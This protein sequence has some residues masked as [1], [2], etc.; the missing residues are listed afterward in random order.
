MRLLA[1]ILLKIMGWRVTHPMPEGIDKAVIIMA[2]HT[3]NWD[4]V[5]GRLGFASQSIKVKIII[6][7]ESFFFPLGILLRWLGAIPVDRG[8][9]A[10][11]IKNVTQIMGNADKFYLLITPEGTRKL[12]KN[13]KKG[14]YFI[15]QQAKVPIIM[16][17]LNYKTK[18]GG[19]GPVLYP[20]GDYE[21]DMKIIED[22]YSD[23]QAM[24]P[25]KF[26]LSP[27][28][29]KLRNSKDLQKSHQD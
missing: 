12:V 29:R 26:N 22:F 8:F 13:W 21:A 7:K 28:N 5:F 24:H 25:E 17:F 19:L 2:P 11:T 14:F 1:S 27:Q 16:G 20:S 18:T 9:S 15:A 10:G 23:K 4:F 6:K 3:S